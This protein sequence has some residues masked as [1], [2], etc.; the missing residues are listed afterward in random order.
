MEYIMDTSTATT[1][2]PEIVAAIAEIVVAETAT[3]FANTSFVITSC[4][5]IAMKIPQLTVRVGASTLGALSRLGDYT[6]SGLTLGS[7]FIT[8]NVGGY[9]ITDIV[10]NGIGMSVTVVNTINGMLKARK[11]DFTGTVELING[12]SDYVVDWMSANVPSA[13]TGSETVI[14]YTVDGYD[15]VIKV[16]VTIIQ[17]TTECIDK[18]KPAAVVS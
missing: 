12:T 8:A 13:M 14:Q 10:V 5:D 17:A 18:I 6:T 7:D 9:I 4:I 16:P 3:D 15:T 1:P 11:A 2:T